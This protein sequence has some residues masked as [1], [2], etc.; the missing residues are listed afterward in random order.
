[1]PLHKL[2]F[3]SGINKES[4]NYANEGGF[5][6]SDKIRF[7]SGYAEKLG[8]WT[9]ATVGGFFLGVCRALV[10]WRNLANTNLIGIGTHLKYYI[11]RD[12]G[13]YY[14]V[15]PLA[16]ESDPDLSD[17]FTTTAGSRI[18]MVTDAQYSPDSGDFVT[19]SGATTF[20]GVTD[21]ILNTEFEITN[22]INTTTY[23]ITLPLGTVPSSSGAGGG[24]SVIAS[25]QINIGLPAA[26]PGNGFGAGFWNGANIST[27]FNTNLA[28]TSGAT[29]WVLLNT[30]STT[31]NVVDTA[32]FPSAGTIIIDAEI[33]TYSG[34]TS[35][36]FTGCVRGTSESTA[37]V[38]AIRPTAGTPSPI[39]VY[40][41]LGL[42][43]TTEWGDA[44]T[45]AG[46]GISLQLRLWTHDNFGQDLL[47][48]VRGGPVYYWENNTSAFPRAVPLASNEPIV[49]TNQVVVSDVSS[50]VICMGC[51][52]YGTSGA[53]DFDP[54]L[55]RW[56]DQADPFEWEPLAT[57]QSGEIRLGNGSFIV[58][59]KKNRQEIVIWTDSAIYSLQ[60]NGPPFVWEPT[61]LMDN[62]SILSPNAAIIVNNIA[63]WMGIDKFYA[64]SGRVDTL[65]CSLR[66][67]VF[68]DLNYDQR[69]QIVA[70][71]NE[72]FNEVWW[73]YVSNDEVFAATTEQ[74]P[75]TVDKYVVYNHLEKIWYYGSMRR[76][77]LLDSGL[78]QFPLTAQGIIPAGLS[79]QDSSHVSTDEGT[80][81]FQENGVDDN[82]T[83]TTVPITAFIQSSDFDIGDGHNFGFVWRMLPDINF[84][85][86]NQNNPSVTLTLLPRQNS[87]TNYGNAADAGVTS[88]NNYFIA[89]QYEVQQF[90]GQV[91]T[92]LRGRQMAFRIE[93]TT[94]GVAWQLGAPR[95]DV[96]QDGRR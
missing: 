62:I 1:M 83:D 74:R 95:I 10:N 7:R 69:F 60:N 90:T 78:Q 47:L 9:R 21:L 73:Y 13:L 68:Q 64:Y 41:V 61:L 75:P 17:P 63:Y 22:V 51:N 71:S 44:T 19:F 84:N 77:F 40:N 18:V 57:N 29:P 59:A 8:G 86:S 16:Y 48:A 81:I 12:L 3:R 49:A 2:V 36:S 96:R 53:S 70:G 87:G 82:S 93:S 88:L 32:S 31:I 58:Q 42:L 80:L 55:V 79:N 28:Y 27:D 38:H 23:E 33:I 50:F 52:P 56:S 66:Q 15:T 4:T 20:N 26:T 92:R 14:D 24:G 37:S 39:V 91:Y 65:P 72:G 67:F 11:N 94:V 35:T 25:Y 76:T 34:K 30:S 85:G 54:M 5:F 89:R 43:G 46:V 6:S 45:G